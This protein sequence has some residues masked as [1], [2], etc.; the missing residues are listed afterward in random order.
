MKN[1]Y[2]CTEN[3]KCKKELKP[4]IARMLDSYILGACI[5]RL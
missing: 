3:I 1:I 5:V 2:N 4:F